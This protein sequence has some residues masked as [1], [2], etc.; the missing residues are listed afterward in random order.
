MSA[1]AWLAII[2]MFVAILL[3]LKITMICIE[4]INSQRSFNRLDKNFWIILV[5]FGSILGQC[6][7]LFSEQWNS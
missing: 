1:I 3:E 6:L 4:R 2:G 7:Y 5:I